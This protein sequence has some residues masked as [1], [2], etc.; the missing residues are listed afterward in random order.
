[1][2]DA[3]LVAQYKRQLLG[4]MPPGDALPRREGTNLD[5]YAEAISVEFAD[6]HEQ[7]EFIISESFPPASTPSGLLP[8][9]EARLGLPDAATY[10]LTETFERQIAVQ[11]RLATSY[12]QSEQDYLDIVEDV[13]AA[14][15]DEI[16]L[17]PAFRTGI[18]GVGVLPIWSLPHLVAMNIFWDEASGTNAGLYVRTS[19]PTPAAGEWYYNGSTTFRI[20]STNIDGGSSVSVPATDNGGKIRMHDST[21]EGYLEVTKTGTPTDN[22]TYWD[23][24]VSFSSD[25]ALL[26]IGDTSCILSYSGTINQDL[27]DSIKAAIRAHAPAH[28]TVTFNGATRY[29]ETHPRT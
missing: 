14:S 23:I 10:A 1:M 25:T 16:R 26:N 17:Y 20:S 4:L 5:Q 15:F 19:S 11:E 28:A 13:Y 3:A 6:L 21:G 9:W 22:T 27:T 18:H 7:I 12:G 29:F 2:A 8:D 24:P